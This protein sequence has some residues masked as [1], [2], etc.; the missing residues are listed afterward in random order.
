MDEKEKQREKML[1]EHGYFTVNRLI[2]KLN[3][4]KKQGHGERLV[5]N[6]FEH[7]QYCEYEEMNNY[8]VI[9]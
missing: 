8:V 6:D 9:V 5:G 3:E 1:K 7:Y 4:L 2:E